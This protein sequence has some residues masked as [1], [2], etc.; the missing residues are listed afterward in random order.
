MRE[1]ATGALGQYL[2]G[3]EGLYTRLVNEGGLTGEDAHR[4]M[5]SVL[6]RTEVGYNPVLAEQAIF[7]APRGAEHM[8]RQG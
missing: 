2:K 1:S 8:T 7:G 4:L 6:A 5:V 3:M